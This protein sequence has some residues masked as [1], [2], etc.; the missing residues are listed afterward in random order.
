MGAASLSVRGSG[1][2]TMKLVEVP[3]EDASFQSEALHTRS[4][5]ATQSL[6]ADSTPLRAHLAADLEHAPA[7]PP[8][9][10]VVDSSTSFVFITPAEG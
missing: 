6:V 1:T 8:P 3:F 5:P 9:Y 4:I 7:N 2:K 10:V